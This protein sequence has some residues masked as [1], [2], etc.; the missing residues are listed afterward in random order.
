M[1]AGAL[2]DGGIIPAYAGSTACRTP[3]S[4][5]TADHPRIRGEHGVAY[6]EKRRKAGSSPHTRGAPIR[7]EPSWR[8]DGIIPAYAGSTGSA[9]S[10]PGN[11]GD[12][13][14]IRGEHLNERA[15]RQR[16]KGSSPHTRGALGDTRRRRVETGIIPAYA[17]STRAPARIPH[18]VQ[19]HPRIRGEHG[20]MSLI[21]DRFRGSSPHTRGARQS[22]EGQRTFR[23]IIPAYAGSTRSGGGMMWIA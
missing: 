5:H 15:A 3:S 18:L 12:H 17:G 1:P 9:R 14:R 11:S 4:T 10:G 13:P 7:A 8:P 19:D 23:G 20:L 21:L 2:G 22:G 6:V 16:R